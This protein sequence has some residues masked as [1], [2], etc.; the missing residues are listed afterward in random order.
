MNEN[1][2]DKPSRELILATAKSLIAAGGH[3]GRLRR[4][5]LVSKKQIALTRQGM[6]FID[7]VQ[8]AESLLEA[9]PNILAAIGSSGGLAIAARSR[10]AVEASSALFGQGAGAPSPGRARLSLGRWL[11]GSMTNRH[12]GA[13]SSDLP[14]FVLGIGPGVEIAL[15]EARSLG[16]PCAWLSD[17]NS[18]PRVCDDLFLINASSAKALRQALAI[19]MPSDDRLPT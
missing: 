18:D 6:D 17:T 5:R 15:R 4:F 9:S 16:I 8:S 14:A 2:E 11:A 19:L 13:W 7:L 1:Y 3:W 10:A 12:S